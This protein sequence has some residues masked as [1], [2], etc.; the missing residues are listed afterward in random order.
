MQAGA[1]RLEEK[2]RWQPV[3]ARHRPVPPLNT[4]RPF[5]RIAKRRSIR[6]ESRPEAPVGTAI[7]LNVG[8]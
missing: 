2:A 5:S 4:Q 6:L 1:P 7:R 3:A 8:E